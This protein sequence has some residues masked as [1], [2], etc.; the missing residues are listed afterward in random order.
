MIT[1]SRYADY[2]CDWI[3]RLDNQ[4]KGR[5]QLEALN[6]LRSDS[7]NLFAVWQWL[8]KQRDY[9]RLIQVLPAYLAYYEY[10]NRFSETAEIGQL[11]REMIQWLEPEC[12]E[13]EDDWVK[14]P[15]AD[16]LSLSM[17]ALRRFRW[18][19][20]GIEPMIQIH[21]KSL[22]IAQ[23]LP[24]N[25]IK[26]LILLMDASGPGDVQADEAIRISR[27]SIEIFERLHDTWG[28]AMATLVLADNTLFGAHD[29]QTAWD[30]Y[31]SSLAIFKEAGN[32]W[33]EAKC[34]FGLADIKRPG[35]PV[36]RSLR[37]GTAKR[38]VV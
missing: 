25:F 10:H 26:A 8:V 4:L 35:R 17:A 31:Q 3:S 7:K 13:N 34:L 20:D 21:R 5:S 2:Y 12:G 36:C 29:S 19:A 33:G 14:A 9:E 32:E 11:L 1:R 37:F 6:L 22:R 18:H 15:H 28:V 23:V 16:L 38:A 27:Q 30:Y 24:D